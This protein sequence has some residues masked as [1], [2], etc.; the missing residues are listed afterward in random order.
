ME[1]NRFK[2]ALDLRFLTYSQVAISQNRHLT[3]S[4]D[5]Q[6]FEMGLLFFQSSFFWVW[7][8]KIDMLT[9]PFYGLSDMRHYHS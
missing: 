9:Q 1:I 3:C 6:N 2:G 5:M 8:L 4:F 7:T